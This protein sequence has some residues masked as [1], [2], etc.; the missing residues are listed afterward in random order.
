MD[1]RHG[2]LALVLVGVVACGQSVR[3]SDEDGSRGGAA[4]TG[5]TGGTLPMECRKF[6]SRATMS[7]LDGTINFECSFHR[8]T[9]AITCQDSEADGGILAMATAESWATIEDAVGENRPVGK[10]KS[11]FYS[12]AVVDGPVACM[13]RFD[14]SFDS[15]GR[16]TSRRATPE[17]LEGP[18]D[19][20][21]ES[22]D[23]WDS[24]GRPTHGSARS[25]GLGEC[26]GQD[27]VIAYDDAAGTVSMTLGEG[28]NCLHTTL[29]WT[30]DADGILIRYGFDETVVNDYTIH[31]T[32][33]ICLE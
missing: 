6:A 11:S 13:F 2:S 17:L 21:S 24:E 29:V 12:T 10:Y 33:E 30:Y 25:A 26:Y 20:S 15:L 3:P 1:P 14:M 31:E 32:Q 28:S 22:Y 8:E 18:C 19:A 5:G 9:L 27:L 23:T 4:G 16:V 7:R